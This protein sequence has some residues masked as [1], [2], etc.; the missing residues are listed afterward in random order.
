MA[1]SVIT[2]I[3]TERRSGKSRPQLAQTGS[4]CFGAASSGVAAMIAFGPANLGPVTLEYLRGGP[5][6]PH[7]PITVRPLREEV[8]WLTGNDA[9]EPVML[10]GQREMLDQPQ[11]VPSG[12][13]HR[14]PEL[15][16]QPHTC[17]G[18]PPHSPTDGSAL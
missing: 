11:A 14:P 10:V 18:V 4:G 7:L 3:T 5:L 1:V 2:C 12:G 13:Q 6:R 17:R 9:T 8:Q 16:L 15:L